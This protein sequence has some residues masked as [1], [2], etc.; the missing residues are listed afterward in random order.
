MKTT[1]NE[2]KVE[3]AHRRVKVR[4]APM[5]DGPRN[6]MHNHCKLVSM[7]AGNIQFYKLLPQKKKKIE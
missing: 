7:D 4:T 6:D 3:T 1:L 5:M 2:E